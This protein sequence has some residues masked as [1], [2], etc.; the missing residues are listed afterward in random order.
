M[1]N[2]MLALEKL[3]GMDYREMAVENMKAIRE[4]KKEPFVL[5]AKDLN[6]RM[7]VMQ[8]GNVKLNE[9]ITGQAEMKAIIVNHTDVQLPDDI[10]REVD[11][12][13]IIYMRRKIY[14]TTAE[15]TGHE[16][17]TD[18]MKTSAFGG[19]DTGLG[20]YLLKEGTHRA[21][22]SVEALMDQMGVDVLIF[23]S[24]IKQTGLRDTGQFKVDKDF[25][26]S[27]EGGDVFTIKADELALNQGVME[28][29]PT[30]EA[31]VK[32]GLS[33][34][35]DEQS[36]QWFYQEYV[37]PS[38][39]GNTELNLKYDTGKLTEEDIANMNV[40]DLSVATVME[41]IH[42]PGD[43]VT[44]SSLYS[45]VIDH[46]VGSKLERGLDPEDMKGETDV[47]E[48][49]DR[50]GINEFNGPADRVIKTM[51]AT[52][53]LT[54]AIVNMDLVRPMVENAVR[55]YVTD[56]GTRPIIENS[57]SAIMMGNDVFTRKE[58]G[59]TLKEGEFM[60][61]AGM[62][63]RKIP[64]IT[65][66]KVRLEDAFNEYQDALK[67][68]KKLGLDEYAIQ[69]ADALGGLT[70]LRFGYEDIFKRFVED[71]NKGA[72]ELEQHLEKLGSQE[73][74]GTKD[75][76]GLSDDDIRDKLY[77]ELEEAF[78]KEAKLFREQTAVPDAKKIKQMERQLTFQGIRVPAERQ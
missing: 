71:P 28:K 66:K 44:G 27:V 58:T 42:Q 50:L 63:D 60:F 74:A 22:E 53:K 72:L 61:A 73:N 21:T 49:F 43:R 75:N 69:V 7:Q 41:I 15:N 76:Y 33:N 34:F 57:G 46:V 55:Q 23:D 24:S 45:K 62:K 5:S 2:N 6:K 77:Y 14:D 25:N 68:G 59:I 37:R 39:M 18:F 35:Q 64:W 9:Q 29:L 65:G 17:L 10:A 26:I 20:G 19:A 52:G 32:Q 78:T 56:R 70:H 36:R 16:P 3:N 31:M 38:I 40:D 1:Y 12:D 30:P 47:N 4:G 67:G 54:P 51:V 8:D 48:V 11:G 13:G